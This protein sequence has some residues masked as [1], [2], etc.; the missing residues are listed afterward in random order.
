MSMMCPFWV[1]TCRKGS[2]MGAFTATRSWHNFLSM[3]ELDLSCNFVIIIIIGSG[4][5]HRRRGMRKTRK[6]HNFL[7]N[8]LQHRKTCRGSQN[9]FHNHI[10]RQQKNARIEG[11]KVEMSN[12]HDYSNK[13]TILITITLVGNGWPFFK[14]MHFEKSKIIKKV[15]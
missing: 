9:I 13:I 11:Q 4:L 14:E 1:G 10:E 6:K 15:P 8:W 2:K 12:G 3:T 5:V 7:I